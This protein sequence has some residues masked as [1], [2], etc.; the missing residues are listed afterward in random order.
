VPPLLRYRY[1]V[2]FLLHFERFEDATEQC[3]LAL[4]N[5]PVSILNHFGVAWSMY[6]AKAYR[7][8]VQYARRA[9][10]IDANFH[11]IWTT[12]GFAQLSAGC[13]QDAIASLQR[14][15]EL[16]PWNFAVLAGL[17]A[18]CHQVGDRERGEHVLQNVSG[19][20]LET[21]KGLFYGITGQRDAMFEALDQ[22]V[23][24]RDYLPLYLPVFE[25][26]RTDPRFQD[27]L[28]QMH[29]A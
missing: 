8:A 3:R 25:P 4:E 23:Q 14:A 28:R 17:A 9:L 18:A 13:A 10:E 26:Y 1:A 29:L 24:K 15:Y 27:L 20:Q 19:R 11:P 12:M 2:F 7:P 21:A 5:D 16:A 6:A 22:S